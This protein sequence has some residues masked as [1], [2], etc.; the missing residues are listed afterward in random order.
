MKCL[1]VEDDVVSNKILN[2]FLSYFGECTATF[3]GDE[4]VEE[5]HNAL[6]L[7]EPF[8]LICMDIMM[9]R[10]DGHEA[11]AQIREL[12]QQ[13]GVNEEKKAKVIMTTCLDEE[14]D[15]RK[16]FRFGCNAFMVKPI[17]QK[18]LVEEIEK[19]GLLK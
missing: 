16:A 18:S 2:S 12:E 19:L 11:L 6:R 17:Y 10:L 14:E 7:N 1:I 15:I 3:D 5:Y 9:P 13:H 4:A 8:D